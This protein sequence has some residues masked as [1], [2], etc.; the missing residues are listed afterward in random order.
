MSH[1]GTGHGLDVR[2][3]ATAL[4][5]GCETPNKLDYAQRDASA[6][7]HRLCG[8]SLQGPAGF[9]RVGSGTAA[10]LTAQYCRS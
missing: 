3:M 5:D 7:L 4:E 8:H 9:V 10:M 2:H 6:L 1:G